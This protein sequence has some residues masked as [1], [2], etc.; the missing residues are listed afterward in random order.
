LAALAAETGAHAATVT[1]VVRGK[2]AVF[3]AIPLKGI[4]ELPTGLFRSAAPDTVVIE[5]GNYYP[6]RDGRIEAIEGG[7]T[8][9]RW[10][11]QQLG[12]PVVKAFNTIHARHLLERGRPK[13][14]S[15][16]IAVSIAGDDDAAKAVVF[17]L[18][19]ELGFD[20]VDAGSL[21]ESWRQ[22]PD[23]PVYGAALGAEDTRRALAVARNER[24]PA[25]RV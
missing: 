8:E 13:G 14:D 19:E 15:A 9:S 23:T 7:M 22:Q 25:A 6:Q 2:D 10:V 1:E 5:T 3:V 16:R 18:I 24:Q 20:G 21:D 17:Q 12:V 11:S 4:T